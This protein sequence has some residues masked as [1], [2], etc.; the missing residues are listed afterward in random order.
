MN[1]L[2]CLSRP[3]AWGYKHRA[4]LYLWQVFPR[5]WSW[6]GVYRYYRWGTVMPGYSGWVIPR[7]LSEACSGVGWARDERTVV[8]IRPGAGC[9]ALAL[10]IHSEESKNYELHSI[11]TF[12]VMM[13][14]VCQNRTVEHA[15]VSLVKIFKPL[16][17]TYS[18]H[19]YPCLESRIYLGQLGSDPSFYSGLSNNHP[20]N[21][22]KCLG[23]TFIIGGKTWLT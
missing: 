15:L 9:W 2:P 1:Q 23:A 14:Y 3:L 11:L 19:L 7:Y 12:Q 13:K 18:F 10:L 6:P 5:P 4:R 20:I 21:V 8:D 22:L 16:N 17:I